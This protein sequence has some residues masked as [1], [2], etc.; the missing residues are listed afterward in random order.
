M[1]F[2]A[3]RHISPWVDTL[4]PPE[5]GPTG[6][7][8]D[9][10]DVL[11]LGA[12]ITGI[13]TAL[14]LQRA[15][16][17]VTVVEARRLAGSVTMHSTVKV[18]YGHGTLYSKIEQ[19]RGFD[20]AAAYAEANVAGFGEIL[21]L[22]RDLNID[23]MLERGHPH[24]IYAEQPEEVE[25]V[26]AEARVA[27]RIGLPVT[28]GQEA[29]VP[30]EVAAALHFTDQAHFHPGRYLA[31][32]AEAFV[33]G[34]GNII[35]GVRAREVSEESHHCTVGTA[36]G[37]LAAAHVVVAT[38]YPFLDRGGQF[39][40]MTARRSYG[41]AAVLPGG[42]NAGMAINAGSPTRSTRTVMLDGEELLIVVGEGHG[43]GHVSETGQRWARLQQWA[44]ERYGVT[45]FRYHWSAEETST[46][47]HVPFVG[48]AAPGSNRLLLAT[49]FDGWGMTNGT[50][51]A[52]LMRD[53]ILERDN[54]W[55]ATFDAR[56]AETSL[57]G[58]E[59]VKHNLHIGKMWL[60]DRV[61]GPP[62][63]SPE[64]LEPG[65]A[66]VLKVDGEQTAAHR[67]E[68]GALHAV[69]AVCT[70]MG[71][72]VGWNDGEKSWDC[73][74]HGSRFNPDGEVLHG[75]ATA[76]LSKQSLG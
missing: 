28:L 66:A 16:L 23:C 24:V 32:L 44:Q 45:D 3:S 8:D 70:H 62:N 31:G 61:G 49:G 69:S 33:H 59:F 56:R 39:S 37:K 72:T 2:P 64:E 34:G 63:G 57:P 53:L 60:K 13:T 9:A 51:A 71:C 22:E 14:L 1:S 67:D 6:F 18:T 40:R 21:A 36:A 12:G 17:K 75:P 19:K 42:S 10:S 25:A 20:A 4:P 55:A 58:K 41:I 65:D 38:H 47:D 7:R 43:V 46:L 29:P 35:E 52:M 54:S 15:G 30:F 48:F 5:L 76:P 11:V 68:N 73:P 74:C 50:A 27:E 26:E